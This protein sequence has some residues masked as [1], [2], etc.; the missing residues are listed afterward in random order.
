MTHRPTFFR[1][2]FLGLLA[3]LVL[4]PAAGAGRGRIASGPPAQKIL[5]GIS[6]LTT[7]DG[8]AVGSQRNAGSFDQGT[9]ALRWNGR[10]W[11]RVP[12]PGPGHS[13]FLTAVSRV[14]ATDAWAVGNT[15]LGPRG[16]TGLIF[17][18]DGNRWTEATDPAPQ[19]YLVGVA[20]TTPS[21]A[22]AVGYQGKRPAMLHW[23]GTA[24]H[25]VTLPAIGDGGLSGVSALSPTDAWA[26]GE[27]GAPEPRKPLIL[28]WNG[29][30]WRTIP[31]RGHRQFLTAVSARAANDVWA[32][33]SEVLH[34]DGTRWARVSAVKG[35]SLEGVSARRARDVWAVGS[36]SSGTLTIHWNGSRWKRVASPSPGAA[37]TGALLAGVFVRTKRDAWAV[38]DYGTPSGGA[39]LLLIHWNGHRWRLG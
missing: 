37:G 3:V 30:S 2:A 19:A 28:H 12:T 7:N 14:S 24:W 4:A 10:R 32:V 25:T 9:L 21:D 26:V 13:D 29:S 33:G 39:R 8:W 5:Y 16:S 20:A 31:V 11:T 36:L 23:D 1:V 27:Y 34:F 22:W 6:A 38:G 15:Y 35:A 17:H 18:W